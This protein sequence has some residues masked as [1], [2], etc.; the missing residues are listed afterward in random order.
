VTI[1]D[2]A[3]IPRGQKF[4]KTW[5]FQNMGKCPWRGYTIVFLS[6]DKME[7]PASATVPE[8]E[9]N[10]TVDISIELVAPSNDGAFT[11]IFELRNAAGRVVPIGTEKSFWVKIT[12]GEGL[13]SGSGSAFPTVNPVIY[14]QCQYSENS[15]Y[16]QQLIS[17]IN[18]ARAD[19]QLPTLTIDPQLTAAAQAHSVDMACGNFLSHGGPNGETIGY[20]LRELG[21]NSIGFREIIAIGTPQDA[22]NQWRNDPGHWEFVL[23]PFGGEIGVGYAYSASSDFGG[24]FTVD[25]DSP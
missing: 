15:G 9:A 17:L 4:T 5:Q 11:G 1:P 16:V 14:A 19:A 22:M 20:R 13:V 6:G 8:T 18:Q 2:H 10:S 7:A 21:Y 3:N 24:Y 23:F 25:F 12:V